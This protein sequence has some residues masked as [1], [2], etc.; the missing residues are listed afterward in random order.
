MMAVKPENR[1]CS[2]C[3][4]AEWKRQ[5]GGKGNRIL[6]D[7]ICHY[8]VDLPESYRDWSGRM[9]KKKHI[10]GHDGKGCPVWNCIGKTLYTPTMMKGI[11]K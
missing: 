3:G 8:E 1:K 9:P 4:W 7:G 11:P 10:N 6:V 5:Q 2:N